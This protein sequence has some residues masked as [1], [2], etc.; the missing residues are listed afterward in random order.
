MVLAS[1]VTVNALWR[2][3]R[4]EEH[5]I[6]CHPSQLSLR[7]QVSS[8]PRLFH[9]RGFA[10]DAE[11]VPKSRVVVQSQRIWQDHLM[12]TSFPDMFPQ[13][14]ITSDPATVVTPQC[15]QMRNTPTGI[16][17]ELSVTPAC[18]EA[19]HLTWECSR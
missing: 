11:M 3:V 4:Q 19:Q 8:S 17:T 15:V 6:T 18:S 1:M 2:E 7:L 14:R 12:S 9:V 5:A 16:Q 10:T 13:A